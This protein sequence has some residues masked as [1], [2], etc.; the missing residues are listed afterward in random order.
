MQYSVLVHTKTVDS[1]ERMRCVAT[2]TSDILCYSLLSN[3]RGI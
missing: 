2:Q 1:V 3:L